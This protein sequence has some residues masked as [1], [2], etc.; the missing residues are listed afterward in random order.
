MI[1]KTECLFV[2]VLLYAGAIIAL[3][4]RAFARRRLLE[5]CRAAKRGAADSAGTESRLV[6]LL[7][8]IP[9]DTAALRGLHTTI[10]GAPGEV[11][12][13]YRSFRLLTWAAV[14]L[15]VCLVFFSIGAQRICQG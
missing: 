6:G 10:S 2:Y 13:T 5:Y 14:I 15:V 4:V 3:F 11:R 7:L 8:S 12:R 1:G 9:R